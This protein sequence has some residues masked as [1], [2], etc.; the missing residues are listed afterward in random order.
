MACSLT[1]RALFSAVRGLVHERVRLS[2]WRKY[3]PPKLKDRIKEKVLSGWRPRTNWCRVHLRYLSTGRKRGLLGYA[4]EVYIDIGGRLT[5]ES[6]ELYLP[7]FRAFNQVHTLRISNFDLTKFLPRSQRYFAQFVPTLRSL[8]LLDIK[9]G[10]HEILEFVCKFP[11][12]DDLSLT[13]SS[14]HSVKVPPKLLV[15]NSP[16]LKGTLV[17]RGWVVPAWFLL[18]IPGG[19]HFRS[20]DVGGVDKA[21]LGVILAACSSELETLSVR[22]WPRKF[23][24][25]YLPGIHCH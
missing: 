6:L 4:R 21:K 25:Y 10:T 8:S 11:H 17:L 5:P 19:L 16:P 2:P 24:Q 9:A 20:I 18:G 12:L 13:L 14:A 15:K 22:P 23:A 1:C 7:H 3:P